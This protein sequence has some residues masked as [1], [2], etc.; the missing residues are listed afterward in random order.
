MDCKFTIFIPTKDRAD[1]LEYTLKTI[2]S[3][4][5]EDIQ[6]IVSDNFS[7]PAVKNLIDSIKDKR[8]EYIR[9]SRSM[10]MSEHWDFALE[11]AKGEWVTFVGDDDGLIPGA[12]SKLKEIIEENKDIRAIT[13]VNSWYRW[14]NENDNYGKLSVNGSKGYEVRDCKKFMHKALLGLPVSQ[15]TIYT[16]GFVR[17]DLVNE[18]KAKSPANKFFNS[19]T[20][21]Y[22]SGMAICSVE[23]KYI[24]IWEPFCIAGTSKH[25]TGFQ[26]KKI[27]SEDRKKMGFYKDC[28][29]K[30]NHVLGEAVNA[31][32]GSMQ[33][34]LYEAYLQSAHLRNYDLGIN[35]EQQLIISI[36]QSSKKI[37]KD[38]IEYVKTVADANNLDFNKILRSA[39]LRR[40]LYKA[41][42]RTLKILRSLGCGKIPTKM[43]KSE[44]LKTVYDAAIKIEAVLKS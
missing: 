15:P 26:H 12:I 20:A 35:L 31:S 33:I 27:S 39:N 10:G 23:D 32:V 42:K 29:I 17:L 44:E 14:P 34:Y 3:Q 5:D 24:Y 18:I 41:R 30:F 4:P 36:S 28:N 13:C 16:G 6:V 8:L 43:Y 21:D 40:P 1:T 38:L 19:I 37:R 2:L 9:T 7:G 11:H 22:Y 25:S